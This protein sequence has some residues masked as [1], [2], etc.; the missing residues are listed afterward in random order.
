M[1]FR[2][3]QDGVLRFWAV[4]FFLGSGGYELV[5]ISWGADAEPALSDSVSAVLLKCFRPTESASLA[6]HIRWRTATVSNAETVNCAQGRCINARVGSMLFAAHH[7]FHKQATW[8]H[9]A[10]QNAFVEFLLERSGP[11]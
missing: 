3:H 5:H 10:K 8:Q 11:L 9:Y 6:R 4:E 7:Q 2:I 1:C